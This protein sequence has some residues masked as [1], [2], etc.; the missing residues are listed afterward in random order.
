LHDGQPDGYTWQ[1]IKT[2]AAHLNGKEPRCLSIPRSLL[3]MIALTNAGLARLLD[4]RPMLTPGKVREI[5]HLDWVC[6]N[7]A[8][9]EATDWQPRILFSEGMKR[10]FP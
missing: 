8:I 4:Y 3:Q 2:V 7:T 6:D 10:L 5:F 9:F 1:K